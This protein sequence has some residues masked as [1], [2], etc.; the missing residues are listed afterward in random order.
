MWS[1]DLEEMKV[2]V[3]VKERRIDDNNIIKITIKKGGD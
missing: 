3:F 2:R 1:Y